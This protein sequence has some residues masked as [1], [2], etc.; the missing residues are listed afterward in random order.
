METSTFAA[1]VVRAVKKVMQPKLTG[2]GAINWLRAMEQRR[3]EITRKYTDTLAEAKK[4]QGAA[5]EAELSFWREPT[6]AG[7]REFVRCASQADAA[8]AVFSEL[9]RRIPT[10]ID[11]EFNREYAK[12]LRAVLVAAARHRRIQAQEKLDSILGH[13][14]E[15]LS[16][17]GFSPDDV[18][19][20]PR[21]RDAS[22]QVERF[23]RLVASI[24]SSTEGTLW[25]HAGQILE[26]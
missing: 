23:E 1:P 7:V 2:E 8:D 21:V 22:R 12:D 14:R 13:S 16:K 5:K 25:Q 11:A 17:E 9:Y 10:A 3:A 26:K 15:A 20:S 19:Q 18:E 4:N 24:E 6:P